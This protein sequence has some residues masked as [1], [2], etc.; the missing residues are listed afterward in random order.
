MR[1]A[2]SV[3]YKERFDTHTNTVSKFIYNDKHLTESS[4]ICNAL[5]SLVQPIKRAKEFDF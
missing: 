4:D 1:A 3:S 5:K 2:Q